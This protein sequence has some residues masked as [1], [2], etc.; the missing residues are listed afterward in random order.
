MAIHCRDV[1]ASLEK[2]NVFVRNSYCHSHWFIIPMEENISDRGCSFFSFIPLFKSLQ[3]TY[4]VLSSIA[5]NTY[6]IL[7]K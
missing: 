4:C 1:I 5:V 7:V 6:I 3:F 2:L